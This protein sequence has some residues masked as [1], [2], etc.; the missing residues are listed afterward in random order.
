MNSQLKFNNNISNSIA[1]WLNKYNITYSDGDTKQILGCMENMHFMVTK[2]LVLYQKDKILHILV[3]Q[4]LELFCAK[5]TNVTN[6]IKKLQTLS[7]DQ[8]YYLANMLG[9]IKLP[10]IMPYDP[11]SDKRNT[12]FVCS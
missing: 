3:S 7:D 11:I 8:Y 12:T 1:N 9:N 6:V 10:S 4:I 2:W 5:E